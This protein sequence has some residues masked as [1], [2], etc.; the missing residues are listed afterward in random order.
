MVHAEDRNDGALWTVNQIGVPLDERF[1]VHLMV[2]NRWNDDID[3]YERT[4]IRPWLSFDWTERLNLAFGYDRH[5]FVNPN[6]YEDRA[7]Q[8][9]AYRH[10]IGHTT[11]RTH[12]WM[13]ERFFQGPSTTAFRARFLIGADRPL[14][15]DLRLVFRNEFLVDLHGTAQ[16]RR[17]GLGE[18]QLFLGVN[19][20]LARWV[21]LELGY[22]MV[23]L[24]RKGP[25]QFNQ[26][27]FLGLSFKT[28]PIVSW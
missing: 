21:N 13:E 17:A 10:E 28:P 11:L 2:Q 6:R 24:D 14:S 9:I 15:N 3:S 4:V 22:L 23:Y 19:H 16:I 7:W 18:D 26:A 27:L 5:E 25:D 1:A 12:L 20:S 8:R